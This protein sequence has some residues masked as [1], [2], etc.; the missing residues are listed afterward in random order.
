ME[1]DNHLD[2]ALALEHTMEWI[3]SHPGATSIRSEEEL[4]ADASLIELEATNPVAVSYLTPYCYNVMKTWLSKCVFGNGVNPTPDA[5]S[6]TPE[7]TLIYNTNA[8]ECMHSGIMTSDQAVILTDT[9]A[10]GASFVETE[11]DAEVDAEAAAE[12]E[13]KQL[14]T[15]HAN[16]M[17]DLKTNLELLDTIDSAGIEL[18]AEQE[19][20]AASLMETGASVDEKQLE[21]V[22]SALVDAGYD[23]QVEAETPSEQ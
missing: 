17:L 18:F 14:A 3:E 16:N 12:M 20:E 21:A 6:I 4:A 2:A 9:G 22:A 8:R 19:D 23:I 7:C 5:L 11:V 10:E 1:L 13:Y 15:E